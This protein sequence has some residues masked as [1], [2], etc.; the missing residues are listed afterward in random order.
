MIKEI[1][2]RCGNFID[3][4]ETD[5]QEVYDLEGKTFFAC[6][7][8]IGES[9]KANEICKK[10]GIVCREYL[11]SKYRYCPECTALHEYQQRGTK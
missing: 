9:F 10:C 4:T 6:N 3:N 11:L 8:C 7:Q 1:C 5:G 2:Y